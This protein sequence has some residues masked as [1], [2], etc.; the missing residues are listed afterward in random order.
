MTDGAQILLVDDSETD[1]ALYREWLESFGYEVIEAEDGDDAL[2]LC[3]E[4]EPAC[5]V[6]DFLML[7]KDGF[8]L[9]VELRRVK[10][11]D[12]PVIFMTEHQSPEI[13][14]DA[15][16]LGASSF[17]AKQDLTQDSLHEMITDLI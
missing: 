7:R 4:Q 14:E 9:L 15:M 6:T 13:I 10:R 16:A 8:Q 5:I 1:R 3:V 11:M 12:T 17:A 2:R